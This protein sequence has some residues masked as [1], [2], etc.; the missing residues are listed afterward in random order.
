M[1]MRVRN[2]G[3]AGLATEQDPRWAAIVARERAADGTFFYSVKTTGVYCRP[4]CAARL[5]NP[6]NVR[7]HPT[8]DDAERAGFRPCKRCK[9]EQMPSA[10]HSVRHKGTHSGACFHVKSA[11][12]RGDPPTRDAS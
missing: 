9:P 3:T 1:T 2:P 11:A 5:A 10:A 6:K 8:C 12:V 4:S 7:F